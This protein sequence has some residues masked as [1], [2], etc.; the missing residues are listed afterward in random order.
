MAHVERWPFSLVMLCNEGLIAFDNAMSI[1][2]LISSPSLEDKGTN[3]VSKPPDTVQGTLS[4]EKHC[5]SQS[6]VSMEVQHALHA[7]LQG[8]HA[9]GCVDVVYS[10][11]T[12]KLGITGLLEEDGEGKERTCSSWTAVG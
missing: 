9:E 7:S 2:V 6:D 10:G 3:F 12:K 11:Q 5:C 4:L 8:D 1:S